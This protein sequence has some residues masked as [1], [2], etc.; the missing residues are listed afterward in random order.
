M[1]SHW[2][3]ICKALSWRVLAVFITGGIAWGLTRE[4]KFAALIGLADSCAKLAVYYAH[5]RVWDRSKFGRTYPAGREYPPD[6][7]I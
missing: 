1:D 5:E 2:R 7:N 6:Y 3:S 4:L